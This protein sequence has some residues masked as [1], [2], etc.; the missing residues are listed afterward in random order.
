M[1]GALTS[2]FAAV[3]IG[4]IWAFAYNRY[5]TSQLIENGYLLMG[6]SVIA[7]RRLGTADTGSEAAPRR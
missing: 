2:G 7:R 3:A 1:L 5:Y 6:D 4:V